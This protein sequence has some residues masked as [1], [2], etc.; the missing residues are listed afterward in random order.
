MDLWQKHVKNVIN[1]FSGGAGYGGLY[2]T[3]DEAKAIQSVQ[4]A[5]KLGL[6]YIDTAP[7]YGEGRSESLLGKVTEEGKIS[8]KINQSTFRFNYTV[9]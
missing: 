9:K 6:N 5:L 3:V 8:M 4:Q 1:I 7:W 2:G